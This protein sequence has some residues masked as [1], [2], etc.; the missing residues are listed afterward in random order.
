MRIQ[1]AEFDR[2]EEA[3]W[4]GTLRDGKPEPRTIEVEDGERFIV[5]APRGTV[6]LREEMICTTCGLRAHMHRATPF[7]HLCPGCE[8]DGEMIDPN[9]LDAAIGRAL[10][11]AEGSFWDV[12]AKA[13]PWID[14][15]DLAPD[16]SAR[17][18]DATELAV[19]AWIEGNRG[20]VGNG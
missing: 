4:D 20:E 17:M 10:I 15:G 13:F 7:R 11:E 18:S 8:H 19:R 1:K 14:S 16:V 9:G 3:G 12:I 5:E 6:D 2:V